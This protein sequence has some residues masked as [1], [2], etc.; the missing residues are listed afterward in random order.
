MVKENK[1]EKVEE[2]EKEEDI[3]EEKKEKKKEVK[4]DSE[5]LQKLV[6][7]LE[8]QEQQI[9][10]L[11]ASADLGRLQRIQGLRNQ[12]KLVKKA[13]ISIYNGKYVLG[14]AKVKDDV[15]FGEDGRLH[16]EQTVELIL[17]NGE[18]K[19][20]IKS[21]VISYR[22]FSRLCQKEE[23]EVIKESKDSDGQTFFTL[24]LAQGRTIELPIIFIN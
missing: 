2:I 4:V 1:I 14:W 6:D 23:G 20:P 10:D 17:D 21:D 3:V 24:Q 7:K 11:E 15:Y 22:T 5:I 13:K 18:G 9:K 12:G 8:K 16:E 19:E